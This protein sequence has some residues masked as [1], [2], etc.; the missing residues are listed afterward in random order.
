[1]VPKVASDGESLEISGDGIQATQ[2]APSSAPNRC[3]YGHYS[4]AARSPSSWYRFQRDLTWSD[5]VDKVIS[6][7]SAKLGLLRRMNKQLDSVALRELYLYCILPAI[8]YGHVVWAGLTASDAKR[9]EKVN[10]NAAR[11]IQKNISSI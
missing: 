5:H 11:V 10:W 6:S 4:A 3:Q 8:E 9:L 2:K 7:A 1:M